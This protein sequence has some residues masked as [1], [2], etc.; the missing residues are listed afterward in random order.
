MDTLWLD[1]G[2]RTSM[3]LGPPG[4]LMADRFVVLGS[5]RAGAGEIGVL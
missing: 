2:R 4:E 5:E 3:P 1:L